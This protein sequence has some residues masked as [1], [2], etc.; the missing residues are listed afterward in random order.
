MMQSR[1]MVRYATAADVQGCKHIA[2]QLKTVFGFLSR[3]VFCDGVERGQLLV[4]ESA[5]DNIFG[6]VRFNHRVRGTETALYDIAVDQQHQRQGIGRSLVQTLIANCRQVQRT[7]IIVRCPLDL[8]A[9]VFYQA[10]GFT[11]VQLEQG[12]RRALNVWRLTIEDV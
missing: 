11:H 7:S 12:R 8:P 1:V 3:G 2:D 10:M 5:T 9:N 4:A 6:F